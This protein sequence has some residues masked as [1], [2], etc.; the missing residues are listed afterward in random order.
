M[1]KTVIPVLLVL[2]VA[3]ILIAKQARQSGA[4]AAGPASVAAA[5]PRLLELGSDKCIPCKAMAPILE[6]L[7]AAYAGKLQVDFIDVWK[8]DGAAK[9]YGVKIIPTQIFFSPD[10]QE[11]FRHQGFFSQEDILSKWAALGVK[12]SAPEAK[13]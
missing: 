1:K 6:A 11:L 5:L 13:E 2:A 3:G 8:D 9:Q 7:K 12:L 10:G 4:P